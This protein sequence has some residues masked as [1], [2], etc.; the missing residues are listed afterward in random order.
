MLLN[1]ISVKDF[2]DLKKCLESHRNFIPVKTG[3]TENISSGRSLLMLHDLQS[4]K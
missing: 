3:K 4:M 1:H 2:R